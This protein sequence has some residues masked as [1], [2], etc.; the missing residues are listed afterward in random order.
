MS[1]NS[2]WKRSESKLTCRRLCLIDKTRFFLC[3]ALSSFVRVLWLIWMHVV[4][5]LAVRGEMTCYITCRFKT[6]V[7]LSALICITKKIILCWTCHAHHKFDCALFWS[8]SQMGVYLKA[9]VVGD[10]SIKEFQIF[11]Y[12]MYLK[13]RKEKKLLLKSCL[14]PFFYSL[15]S[16]LWKHSAFGQK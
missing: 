14:D 7:C 11:G 2:A 10:M 9:S 13:K 8:L 3:S 5:Y 15:W 4:I 16:G 6:D 1:C 12:F